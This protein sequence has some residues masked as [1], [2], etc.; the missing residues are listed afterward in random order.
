MLSAEVRTPWHDA[1][2]LRPS[3]SIRFGD[4]G[5]TPDDIRAGETSI[6]YEVVISGNPE[7]TPVRRIIATMIVVVGKAAARPSGQ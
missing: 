1:I 4:S 6:G 2:A 5:L 7:E 3:T